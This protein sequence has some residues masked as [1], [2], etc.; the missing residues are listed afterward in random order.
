MDPVLLTIIIVLA[1]ALLL[2]TGFME[3]IGLMNVITPR[4]GPRYEGCGHFKVQLTSDA[5]R[6]WH[7]RHERLE[8]ALHLPVRP[9]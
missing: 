6:C 3:W 5:D 2:V 7:C 4:T 9:H 8:H 1:T